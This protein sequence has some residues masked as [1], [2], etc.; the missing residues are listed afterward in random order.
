MR[1]HYFYPENDLALA[2]GIAG[3][4]PPQ[5]GTDMH[6]SGEALPLWY[7]LPGDRFITQGLNAS[8]F[9]A[10]R[11][12]FDIRV[13]PF[14]FNIGSLVPAPW[15][16]SLPVRRMYLDL[17]FDPSALP[18]PEEIEAIRQLS[19]RRTASRLVSALISDLDFPIA[20]PAFETA[21]PPEALALIRSFGHAV[22]KQPWSSSGRGIALFSPSIPDEEIMRRLAGTIRR[23]DSVLIEPLY[24]RIA[25]FA[26]LFDIAGGRVSYV[27]L[28]LFSVDSR[29]AYTGNFVSS[30][31]RLREKFSAV[32]DLARLDS[33]TDAVARRIAEIIGDAY[34]GPLGVDM[35]V[36]DPPSGPRQIAVSEIN[37]RMTMGH[38]A[39][40][41][42]TRF[43]APDSEGTYSVGLRVGD[44]VFPP[45]GCSLSAN[46]I[47]SG[48]LDLVPPG[49]RFRF[50]LS[51]APRG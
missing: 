50:L 29:F 30:E 39:H 19:H 16:W 45:S 11:E 13:E 37:L 25:D 3:F 35:M 6:L 17:G 27:G 20:N 22:V 2:A 36:I 18:S 23:Q 9:S 46:R 14:A 21:S 44:E 10:I 31:S 15:G 42:G 48:N 47:S 8:W 41:L 51:V 40:A 7:G 4:T 32:Y 24:E 26:L 12:A 38:V 34:S 1:L 43:L 28:S 5:A 33:L 49:G